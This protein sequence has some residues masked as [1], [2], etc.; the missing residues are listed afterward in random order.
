MSFSLLALLCLVA[1]IGPLLNL[2]RKFPVPMVVGE[3]IVGII[4]GQTGLQIFDASD[5][6]FTFMAEVGFALVMFA[7]GA[8]V[9]LGPELLG[10][11]LRNGA[12]R[13][14]FVGALSV[15][16]GLGL[17][18]LFGSDNGLLYAVILA[19]SSASLVIPSM[20]NTPIAGRRGVEF[21]V[22]IAIADAVAIVLLPLAIEPSRAAR[23]ALGAVIVILVAV[24]YGIFMDR[25][26]MRQ[27]RKVSKKNGFALEIRILLVVLFSLA[28]IAVAM[29]VSVM[30][31][32][33]A[34]GIAA[35]YAGQ[36]KRLKRQTFAL[37]EG[38]FGPLFFV[39]L[40]ASIDLR[41]LAEHPKAIGLGLGLGLAGLLVHGASGFLRLPFPLAVATG[42]QLGVPIGAVTLALTAG[43]METWEAPAI[44]LGAVVTIA[45]V[46]VTM[47]LV[48]QFF[49]AQQRAERAGGEELTAKRHVDAR[50]E[51]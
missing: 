36:P 37:T 33:F 15:A 46:A 26:N 47:P 22:Q 3:L 42:G 28:A 5:E 44:F 8:H 27:V 30:L 31:A 50:V 4:V 35:S 18:H 40:G 49:K 11:A 16:A 43:T 34:L 24:A 25:F 19:S 7:A 29:N 32:G 21:L 1:L 9:P 48:R 17:A 14:A 10:P 45:G 41:Q 51:G 39:W 13:A 6:T 12:L 38:L 23:A 2:N 20:G